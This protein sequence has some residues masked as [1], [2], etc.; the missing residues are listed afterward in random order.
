MNWADSQKKFPDSPL[1]Y[2]AFNLLWSNLLALCSLI[3]SPEILPLRFINPILWFISWSYGLPWYLSQK[4]NH[5]QCR[6][7]GFVPW[8]GNIPWRRE[9]LPTTVFLPGESHGQKSQAGYSPWGRKELDKTDWLSTYIIGE[10]V[11][12]LMVTRLC[13]HETVGIN[14]HAHA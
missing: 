5:L 10:P 4:R 12:P 11:L 9:W 3:L 13:L 6:R 2:F 1:F 7:P 8:V 14:F